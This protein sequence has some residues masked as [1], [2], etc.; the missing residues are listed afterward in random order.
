MHNFDEGMEQ[1]LVSFQFRFRNARFETEA[2]S[3][4]RLAM[5]GSDFS[6][7]P[8]QGSGEAPENPKD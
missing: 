1:K 4:T 5:M 8:M 7:I 2:T 3:G 6:E